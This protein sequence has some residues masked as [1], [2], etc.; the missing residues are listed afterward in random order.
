MTKAN[1]T[2]SSLQADPGAKLH[3]VPQSGILSTCGHP[4]SM[5]INYE[6]HS[7]SIYKSKFAVSIYKGLLA[8][9][10]VAT[11]LIAVRINSISERHNRKEVENYS[12][13]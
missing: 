4:Q 5:A 2:C 12:T 11:A 8:T 10:R 6:P 1:V 3:V 13:N 9:S 7:R